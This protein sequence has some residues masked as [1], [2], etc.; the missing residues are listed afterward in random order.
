MAVAVGFEDF[1]GVRW[2]VGSVDGDG[3]CCGAPPRVLIY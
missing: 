3:D 2:L 1:A